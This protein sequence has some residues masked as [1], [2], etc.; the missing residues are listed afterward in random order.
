MHKSL[1]KMHKEISEVSEKLRDA[2]TRSQN[3]GKSTMRINFDVGDYVLQGNPTKQRGSKLSI[4]W[5][6]PFIISEFQSNSIFVIKNWLTS[7]A[8]IFHGRRLKFFRNSLFEVI[9]E[10]KEQLDYQSH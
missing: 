1:E 7:V 5:T 6:G 4:Q 3:N 10:L 8:D 9:K 2:S